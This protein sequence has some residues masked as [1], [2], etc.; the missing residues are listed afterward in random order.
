VQSDDIDDGDPVA[1]LESLGAAW[2]RTSAT[3]NYSIVVHPAG[4]ATSIHQCL[5]QMAGG[6]I[7]RQIAIRMCNGEG[8][9]ALTWDPP[10][11]WR[12]E[13]SNAQ[14]VSVLVSTPGG[15]YHCHRSEAGRR[16]CA[17]TSADDLESDAPSGAIF[18]SPMQILRELG[19][20]AADSLTRRP[21]REIAGT[22]AECF[23]AAVSVD[24]ADSRRAD[25]CYS[26]D[27]VLLFSLVDLAEL[28]TTMLEAIEVSRGVSEG[29]FIIDEAST[30]VAVIAGT[31]EFEALT[32]V[33]P[34]EL[35]PGSVPDNRHDLVIDADGSFRWGSWSGYVD[36]SGSG[37]ALF[38]VRPARLGQDF[39]DYGASAGITIE[40]DEMRIWLP[41]LGR[42]RDVD[43]GAAVEDIDSPDMAFRKVGGG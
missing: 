35:P 9:L 29:D 25:W 33:P 27:G 30:G 1:R 7:D 14:G 38:V 26:Q 8:E 28:G 18:L 31:W 23:S 16:R 24:N 6:E 2:L 12:L 43:I 22:S 40:G 15:A 10:D 42:D 3:V 4:S 41:D 19:P 13:V 20:G 21:D 5:R 11:R 32:G 39:V 36:A 34:A 17:P 37:F